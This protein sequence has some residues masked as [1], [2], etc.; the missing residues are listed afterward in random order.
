MQSSLID[1]FSYNTNFDKYNIL[2]I[3]SPSGFTDKNLIAKAV[4]QL[5]ENDNIPKYFS[6][7]CVFLSA[8][9]VT[10]SE[11]GEFG[12]VARSDWFNESNN[13]TITADEFFT[14]ILP[15]AN[16][17][18]NPINFISIC[19]YGENL[20]SSK[21]FS[22]FPLGTSSLVFSDHK[23]PTNFMALHAGTMVDPASLMGDNFLA[24]TILIAGSRQH[25]ATDLINVLK[26]AKITDEEDGCVTEIL[27]LDTIKKYLRKN[28]ISTLH[29]NPFI[30]KCKELNIDL[31]EKLE[32]TE[33][34]LGDEVNVTIEDLFGI[35][36]DESYNDLYFNGAV[37]YFESDFEL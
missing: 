13:L 3:G 1:L 19:C 11:S 2:T 31:S 37:S 15:V 20:H 36:N 24:K 10:D 9:G 22:E 18:T 16:I 21:I 12:I 14:Q 4:S 35:E 17:T 6:Q 25:S 32:R 26:I 30:K 7:I 27:N 5:L 33:K 23:T 28:T 8:H 34:L 29:N